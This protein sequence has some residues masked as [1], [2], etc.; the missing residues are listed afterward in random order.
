MKTYSEKEKMIHGEIYNAA[1]PRLVFDR[2]RAA[3]ILAKYN[4]KPFHEVDMRNRL[5]RKLL[6]TKGIFWI[7]P[8]FY[9]NTVIYLRYKMHKNL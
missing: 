6:H 2:D 8:P 3:R 7:K 4:W 5:M 1:D 9:V